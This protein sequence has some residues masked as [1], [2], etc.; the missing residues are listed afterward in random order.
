MA[1]EPDL[2]Q[3]ALIELEPREIPMNERNL[4]MIK[5][6]GERRQKPFCNH[7]KTLALGFG[8]RNKAREPGRKNI[9]E[10]LG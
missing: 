7:L 3:N 6:G 5:Q 4:R 2:F 1:R 9:E 10:R 8:D